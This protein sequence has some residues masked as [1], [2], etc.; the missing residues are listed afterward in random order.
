MKARQMIIISFFIGISCVK[1]IAQDVN[2]ID[3]YTK[4]AKPDV[5][6]I[7][8][9]PTK[10]KYYDS[11]DNGV[12]EWYYYNE[13]L[14]EFNEGILIGFSIKTDRFPVM[15]KDVDGGIRVGDNISKLE[16]LKPYYGRKGDEDFYSVLCGDDYVVKFYAKGN[17]ITYVSFTDPL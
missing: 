13:D 15:T 1:A 9:E 6:A 12:D 17:I 14:L 11:Q 10:Y 16:Q 2:G 3:I 8:G 4:M 7:M 5:I